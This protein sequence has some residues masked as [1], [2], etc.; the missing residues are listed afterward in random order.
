MLFGGRVAV[1]PRRWKTSSM[2]KFILREERVGNVRV[3]ARLRCQRR[4]MAS[5]TRVMRAVATTTLERKISR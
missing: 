3:T 4:F 2:A 5:S 1:S